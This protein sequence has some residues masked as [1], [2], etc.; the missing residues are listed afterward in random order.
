MYCSETPLYLSLGISGRIKQG[1]LL[2]G[3]NLSLVSEMALIKFNIK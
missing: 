3:E 1:K 2:N